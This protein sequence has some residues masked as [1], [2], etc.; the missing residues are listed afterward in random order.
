MACIIKYNNREYSE[1]EFR[2]YLTE[3]FSR[4]SSMVDF[5]NMGQS[6]K[7]ADSLQK[8]VD[9]IEILLDKLD[10]E[11][12]TLNDLP[13]NS[14]YYNGTMI[15]NFNKINQ[16]FKWYEFSKPF[17]ET[18]KKTN[19][20]LYDEVKN[21]IISQK[22]ILNETKE[23]HEEFLKEIIMNDE[24]LEDVLMSE[25]MEQAFKM[26]MDGNMKNTKNNLYL[27]EQLELLRKQI[28]QYSKGFFKTSAKDIVLNEDEIKYLDENNN[29]CA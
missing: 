22:N 2:Q 10:M 19:G 18:V 27:I 21:A 25:A 14:M 16:D 12:E 24:A 13:M 15:I 3:N 20:Y 11:Y 1:S 17:I 6:S 7:E 28:V 26:Y 29:E 5:D 9:S 23:N 8:T 4:F